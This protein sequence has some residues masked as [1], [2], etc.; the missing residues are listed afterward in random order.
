MSK[1]QKKKKQPQHEKTEKQKSKIS[2]A[3]PATEKQ[4]AMLRLAVRKNY[5]FPNPFEKNFQ[6]WESLTAGEAD[7]I[8]ATISPERLGTLEKEIQMYESKGRKFSDH[9]LSYAVGRGL[10]DM[11]KQFGHTIDGGI[12]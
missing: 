4:R 10:E 8:L 12:S 9:H 7:K 3:E 2:P 6:K 1:K 11:T 5:L